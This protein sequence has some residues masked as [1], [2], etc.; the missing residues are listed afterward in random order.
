MLINKVI[1]KTNQLEEMKMFYSTILEMAFESVSSD[2]FEM[3]F[4]LT[5][6]EFTNSN[7]AGEPFYHFAF[8]IPSN[9]FQKAKE[10]M[11]RKV[12][13]LT[14]DDEDEVYFTNLKAN[15][16][17]FED[18]SGNIIEFIARLE[19]NATSGM[20]FTTA[21]ILK[22]S[23]ISLVVD[24]KVQVAKQLYKLS[25]VERDGK[26]VTH[27]NRLHFMTEGDLSVYLLLVNPRRRWYFSTKEATVHPLDIL[28]DSEI[29]LG[30]N[31]E[32]KFY[33]ES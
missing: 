2:R 25:I 19:H 16:F 8:D 20:P 23:E 14:E 10:W 9:Q 21:N 18:P 31:D 15:S 30:I 33:V 11:K 32:Y 24:D 22:M 3:Q 6:V 7:V 26:E 29:K 28:I 1:L 27:D 17:Y 5:T 4:G 13:L 12:S